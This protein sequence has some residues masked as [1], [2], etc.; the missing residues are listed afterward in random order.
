MK[1]LDKEFRNY[2]IIKHGDG[3]YVNGIAH[4]NTVEGYFSI[5]KRGINEAYHHVSKQHL[6]FYINEFDFRHNYRKCNDQERTVEAVRG[7]E[8]KRLYYRDLW[9]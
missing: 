4:T 5:L 6:P 9:R 7:F 1:E 3:Q 8:G 2:H